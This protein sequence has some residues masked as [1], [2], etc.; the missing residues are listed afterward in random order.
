[1][2]KARVLRE[3]V[4][5]VA[6]AVCVHASVAVAQNS[7]RGTM[8]IDDG[9]GHYVLHYS[10]PDVNMVVAPEFVAADR[11][12]FV[13]ELSLSEAQELAVERALHEY[14]EAFEALV[15]S[16]H[17]DHE[18]GA[19]DD[20]PA[21]DRGADDDGDDSEPAEE[22]KAEQEERDAMRS[23]VQEEL[24]NAGYDIGDWERSPYRPRIGISVSLSEDETGVPAEP[25]VDVNVSFGGEDDNLSP[26]QREKLKPVAD[27]IAKR[28]AEH[29]KAKEA[30]RMVQ[31][32]A[33]R[34]PR[35]EIEAKWNELEALRKRIAEFLKAKAALRNAL[36]TSI[37]SVLSEEQM[38]RW[39]RLVRTLTRVKTLQWG[40]F[41]GERTDLLAV[42]EEAE[43]PL[44]TSGALSEHAES[45][46]DQLHAALQRRNELLADI[47]AQIDLA[48]YEG[49]YERA[50]ALAERLTKSRLAVRAVND[51][52]ADTFAAALPQEKVGEFRNANL[53]A[54]YPRVYRATLATR[55]FAEATKLEDMS[56]DQRTALSELTANYT[57]ELGE[58]NDRLRRAIREQDEND[59]RTTLESVIKAAT[60]APE[61]DISIGG[62][63]SIAADFQK[64]RELDVRYMKSLYGILSPQQVAKLPRVPDADVSE[65]VTGEHS[66]TGSEVSE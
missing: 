35:E 66:V 5:A 54:S 59:L 20:R 22:A 1:M 19:S 63:S 49:R 43:I 18:E 30:A 25:Q 57:M 23:I 29:V 32:R 61:D 40:Q 26:E 46:A 6:A 15:R 16:K 41:D 27:R 7:N 39:P 36:F 64:R 12:I 53:V 37:Q 50:L 44:D 58:L 42:L 62:A 3:L 34:S 56:A 14:I 48:M 51:Q 9:T 11:L 17:P 45:Y 52:F 28:L 21:P 24:K 33:E 38:E 55:S 13:E 8:A 60:A 65:R 4:A 10:E 2:S 31:P 47:D